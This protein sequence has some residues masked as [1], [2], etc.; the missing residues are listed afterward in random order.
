MNAEVKRLC[1]TREWRRA[2]DV[3]LRIMPGPGSGKAESLVFIGDCIIKGCPEGT[4][5]DQL[6]IEI[7]ESLL[8]LGDI[9]HPRACLDALNDNSQRE[10]FAQ[11]I[12]QALR[13]RLSDVHEN[14]P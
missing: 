14:V 11:M 6:L 2:I 8:H 9:E 3:A 13:S 7:I 12:E 1:A 4:E 5:R 10:R